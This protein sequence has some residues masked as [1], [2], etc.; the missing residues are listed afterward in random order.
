MRSR[1]A[2]IYWEVMALKHHI[3][4]PSAKNYQ[5]LYLNV[6]ASPLLHV[7]SQIHLKRKRRSGLRVQMPVQVRNLIAFMS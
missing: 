2:P 6:N 7:R 4:G 3:I 1:L 5:V